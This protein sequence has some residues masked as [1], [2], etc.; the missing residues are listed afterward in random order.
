M[1]AVVL[2]DPPAPPPPND[3]VDTGP[4]GGKQC[5]Q[6]Q[7]ND[8]K[9]N[10]LVV[11]VYT[12]I[13]IQTLV[14]YYVVKRA[15][16][17]HAHRCIHKHTHTT[18]HAHTH[19]H[20]HTHTR[21]HTHTHTHVHTH[22]H[23][24]THTQARTHTHCGQY[25]PRM[26]WTII[27]TRLPPLECDLHVT[28]MSPSCMWHGSSDLSHSTCMCPC[29]LALPIACDTT[30]HPTPGVCISS[31]RTPCLSCGVSPWGTGCE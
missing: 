14:L 22:T 5:R 10:K 15:G 29:K 4:L 3:V 18:P 27:H 17:T 8:H 12:G 13:T 31:Q 11:T 1:K 20:T 30:H 23:T 7:L 6:P 9:H 24:Y 19:T 26:M 25:Q 21:T 16:F 2:Y 28:S